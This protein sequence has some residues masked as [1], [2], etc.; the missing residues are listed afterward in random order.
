M[1]T[2]TTQTTTVQKARARNKKKRRCVFFENSLAAEKEKK[3]A[4]SAH[5]TEKKL[6]K[7][8]G[9]PMKLFLNRWNPYSQNN[10]KNTKKQPRELMFNTWSNPYCYKSISRDSVA[11]ARPPEAS[12]TQLP[13]LGRAPGGNT[14]HLF[15]R[16]SFFSFFGILVVGVR[17]VQIY[18]RGFTIFFCQKFFVFWKYERGSLRGSSASCVP[19]QINDK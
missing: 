14:W 18:S 4:K 3:V 1:I 11:P 5:K 7:I 19:F 8:Y 2:T 16:V 17:W 15:V 12:S 6:E 13:P 9:E 10:E